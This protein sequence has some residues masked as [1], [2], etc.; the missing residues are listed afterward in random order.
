MDNDRL[1]IIMSYSHRFQGVEG[2]FMLSWVEQNLQMR[3]LQIQLK[4]E[5]DE[6]DKGRN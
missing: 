2:N 5:L 1:Y 4:E 6:Y 3:D